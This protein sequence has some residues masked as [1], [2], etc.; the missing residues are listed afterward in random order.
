MRLWW[1]SLERAIACHGQCVLGDSR[2]LQG[3]TDARSS[4]GRLLECEGFQG[5]AFD[6][7]REDTWQKCRQGF[8][9]VRRAP[10]V[11]SRY[12][13]MKGL[14]ADP[15]WWSSIAGTGCATLGTEVWCSVL[16][17]GLWLI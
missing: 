7:L 13:D 5:V 15:T 6:L 1:R 2:K 17:C 16:S 3:L 11:L 14:S 4:W 9:R 8:R 10:L 12:P